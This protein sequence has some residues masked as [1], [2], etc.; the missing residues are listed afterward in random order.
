MALRLRQAEQTSPL[1][2][3]AYAPSQ[4]NVRSCLFIYFLTPYS[5]DTEKMKSS[6][7]SNRQSDSH[8][9]FYI[10]FRHVSFLWV[11]DWLLNRLYAQT[12]LI[13][14]TEPMIC[15]KFTIAGMCFLCSYFILLYQ[16]ISFL[17]SRDIFG[18]LQVEQTLL[19]YDL[20]QNIRSA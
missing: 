10:H 6:T 18:K 5:Y 15:G 8:I 11:S 2:I 20:N 4:E 9:Y 12:C 1:Y 7:M 14:Y 16:L 17:L 3:E 19:I 13:R